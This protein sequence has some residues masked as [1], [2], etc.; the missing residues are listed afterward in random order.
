MPLVV[1]TLL[2]HADAHSIGVEG[3]G[4][5]KVLHVELNLAFTEKALARVVTY[6]EVKPLVMTPCV[7][8]DSHVQVVLPRLNL[9]DLIQV[10]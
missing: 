10:P 2:G 1:L 9:N 3:C 4:L 7:R 6:A 5:S 8:I